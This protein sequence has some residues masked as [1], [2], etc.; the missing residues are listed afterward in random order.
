MKFF[1]IFLVGITMISRILNRQFATAWTILKFFYC[2]ISI[3][4]KCSNLSNFFKKITNQSPL[5]T[6]V[7][8]ATK[9]KKQV[10]TAPQSRPSRKKW[11]NFSYIALRISVWKICVFLKLVKFRGTLS[12]Q[13]NNKH[14]GTR[15]LSNLCEIIGT[16]LWPFLLAYQ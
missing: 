6:Y 5:M 10:S 16:A 2:N 7:S 15:K 9:K 12:I 1:N 13:L 14:A 4:W 11:C 3:K 8:R